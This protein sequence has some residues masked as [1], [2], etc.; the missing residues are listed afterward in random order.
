MAYMT[1]EER[2]IANEPLVNMIMEALRA[3]RRG[4]SE[5]GKI[6]YKYLLGQCV[7]Q[8][9]VP[10]KNWHLSKGA[11]TQWK[12]MTDKADIVDFSYHEMIS[13]TEDG[14]IESFKGTK[15]TESKLIKYK[16]GEKYAFITFFIVEHTIPVSDFL[17]EL[18]DIPIEKFYIEAVLDKLHLTRLLRI[19][20][21]RIKRDSARIKEYNKRHPDSKISVL[22]TES[23]EL[24]KKVVEE[25]YQ[26]DIE[27]HGN[28]RI[29]IEY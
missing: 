21:R 7:R 27:K 10:E 20:D 19:E 5:N 12:K 14:E 28:E 18:N 1:E 9:I 16:K 13:I 11:K 15:Q 25:F 23:E 4:K 22:G 24:F 6:D 26:I 17:E 3:L 29:E 8:Y 2:R